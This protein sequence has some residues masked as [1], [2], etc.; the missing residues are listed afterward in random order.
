MIQKSWE[1]ISSSSLLT[2]EKILTTEG[3]RPQLCKQHITETFNRLCLQPKWWPPLLCVYYPHICHLCKRQ[4]KSVWSA[5]AVWKTRQIQERY[6]I[7]ALGPAS[8]LSEIRFFPIR[9]NDPIRL[10]WAMTCCI[11]CQDSL[12][13][14]NRVISKY[15]H[16]STECLKPWLIL[17]DR[18]LFC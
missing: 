7:D 11:Y 13:Q 5:M 3:E 1:S 10:T 12:A 14:N 2:K 15:V 8:A 9:I 4:Q 6:T 17:A 16:N 18:F